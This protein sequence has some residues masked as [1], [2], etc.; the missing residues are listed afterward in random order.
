MSG[1]SS[2]QSGAVLVCHPDPSVSSSAEF[3]FWAD[4]TE[5][6]QAQ[7]EVCHPTCGPACTGIHTIARLGAAR[8]PRRRAGRARPVTAE[9]ALNRPGE[10]ML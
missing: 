10:V 5:A 4:V 9:S 6:R 7:A 3:M 2:R 1:P 8:E